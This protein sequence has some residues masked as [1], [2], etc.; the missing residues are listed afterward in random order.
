MAELERVYTIPLGKSY[1]YT[2]VRRARTAVKMIRS[3]LARH[4]KAGEDDV[5]VSMGINELVWARGIQKPPR[6]IKIR[7]VKDAGRVLAFL[8]DEKA[9][10]VKEEKKGGKKAPEAGKKPEA[11]PKEGEEPAAKK[12]EPKKEAPAE[13]KKEPAVAPGKPEKK[14]EVKKG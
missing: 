1:D 12:E 13:Q 3:F 11:A 6:K 14:G 5:R 10:E 9:G 2:R 7:A 8:M 4:M